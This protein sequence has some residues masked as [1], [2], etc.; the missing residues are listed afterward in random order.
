MAGPLWGGKGGELGLWGGGPPGGQPGL[1]AIDSDTL[2]RLRRAD[3]CEPNA[4]I[5]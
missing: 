4:G 2:V 5:E 3:I 1:Q